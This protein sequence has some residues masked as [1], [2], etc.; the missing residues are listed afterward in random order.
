MQSINT[1]ALSFCSQ[2]LLCQA[3]SYPERWISLLPVW[4][5]VQSAISTAPFQAGCDIRH[6]TKICIQKKTQK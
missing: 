6:V 4:H 1:T 2:G 3:R 5:L